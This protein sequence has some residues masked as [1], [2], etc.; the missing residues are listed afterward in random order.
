MRLA[1]L[2]AR[3][4]SPGSWLLAVLYLLIVL[5]VTFYL[6]WH[7]PP[8][9][10]ADE[11]S[12]YLR[13]VQVAQGGLVSVRTAGGQIGGM[14]PA[15]TDR[16]AHGYADF[17]FHSHVDVPAQRYARDALVKPGV[18]VAANFAN[19]AVYPPIFYLPAAAGIMIGDATGRGVLTDLRLARLATALCATLVAASAIAITASGA[20]PLFWLLCLPMTLSLFA[21]CS[22]DALVIACSAL[23]SA[24]IS[25]LAYRRHSGPGA[26]VAVAAGLGCIAAAKLPYLM[27]APLPP[28]WAGIGRLRS[29]RIRLGILG[30]L[31]LL[32]LAVGLGWLFLG[33]RAVIAPNDAGKQMAWLVAHPL[34]IPDIAIQTLHSQ[35]RRLGQEFIGVLGWLDVPLSPVFY[36]ISLLVLCVLLGQERPGRQWPLVLPAT[37]VM[38]IACGTGIFGALYLNWTRIGAT[39]VDGLQGRYFIPLACFGTLLLRPKTTV[40]RI[41]TVVCVIWA[42][43]AAVVTILAI[44]HHYTPVW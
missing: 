18:P 26:W 23:V 32:P 41:N 33:A 3:A 42:V 24:S 34:H 17:R 43:T 31:L 38:I 39:T 14:L 30:S 28:L 7:M 36:G 1:R 20:L 8:F 10:S 27:L 44:R 6:S 12:H 13:A 35:A 29:S 21:S 11:D 25:R 37:L 9:Q 40:S 5:P 4:T 15:G 16:L 22:Q 19:T 2:D